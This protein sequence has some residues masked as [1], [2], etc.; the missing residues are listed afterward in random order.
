MNYDSPSEINR[1]L[2]QNGLA[3]KK[4]FGQNFL[5]NRGAREK[6]VACLDLRPGETVWEIGPGLGA[7]TEL[8]LERAGRVV[9]FEIDGGFVRL[10]KKFFGDRPSFLLV[11]GDAIKRLAE[12]RERFG[13]P[14]RLL[15]NLPYSSASQIIAAFIEREIAPRRLTVTVQKEMAL[16][17]RARPGQ[18]NYSSFS[19]LCQSF[20][21]IRH[22]FDLKGGSFHPRPEVE[23]AV[24]SLEPQFTLQAGPVR[25]AFF[26]LIRA[27]FLSRRKTLAN[28][29]FKGDA[30]DERERQA[31]RGFLAGEHVSPNARAEELEPKM[32][33][34]AA[35]ALA[36]KA[37]DAP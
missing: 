24:V 5:I 32:F 8:L 27:S 34:R 35:T 15:G 36:E 6:I 16:R 17:L 28:N 7:M 3:L 4:R 2:E 14:D 18:K 31:L 33:Q 12:S 23:S 26:R 22:E 19:V 37:I 1:V 10:L 9:V 13:V 30:F 29:L 21:E 25:E 20:F 11:E